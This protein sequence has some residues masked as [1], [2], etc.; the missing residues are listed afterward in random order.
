M[1][2]SYIFAA[3]IALG[4]SQQQHDNHAVNKQPEI[5]GW[6]LLSDDLESGLKAIEAA[7]SYD[8]N[9]LQLSPPPHH[10]P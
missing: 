2:Y 1:R 6:N 8:I 10:G 4:C 5:R 3:F 9:H 7:P